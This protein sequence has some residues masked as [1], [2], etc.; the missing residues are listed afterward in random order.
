MV[1]DMRMLDTITVPVTT[2]PRVV[3]LSD[4]TPT[5]TRPPTYTFRRVEVSAFVEQV[6]EAARVV[7]ERSGEPA[8]FVVVADTRQ[9]VGLVRAAEAIGAGEGDA[10]GYLVAGIRIVFGGAAIVPF[11]VARHPTTA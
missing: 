8:A 2:V 1:V 9:S 10:D 5:T 11:G 6:L 4:A 3:S 7:H